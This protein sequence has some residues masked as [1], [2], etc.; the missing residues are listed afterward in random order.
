MWLLNFILILSGSFSRDR[1]QKS[2]R[3]VNAIKCALNIMKSRVKTTYSLV[4]SV[5][6][7]IVDAILKMCCPAWSRLALQE[8]PSPD[9]LHLF[10]LPPRRPSHAALEMLCQIKRQR[11]PVEMAA[12][13]QGSLQ[14]LQAVVMEDAVIT[15]WGS[16]AR[17]HYYHISYFWA[18]SVAGFQARSDQTVSGAALRLRAPSFCAR[19]AD[20]LPSTELL[21][22]SI[23]FKYVGPPQPLLSFP[24]SCS[25]LFDNRGKWVLKRQLIEAP[26]SA[27]LSGVEL[28]RDWRSWLHYPLI[29]P[30]KIRRSIVWVIYHNGGFPSVICRL[31]SPYNNNEKKK[32]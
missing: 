17:C 4:S 29:V 8:D 31:F 7:S 27:A 24:S 14:Q 16:Y 9:A 19:T 20:A 23:V 26:E 6:L 18:A 13:R 15:S 3:A 30:P 10:P 5:F 21:L 11:G 12:G 28:R 25:R 22:C 32:N 1:T 2:L